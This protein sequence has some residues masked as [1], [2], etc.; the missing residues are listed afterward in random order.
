V[1][2]GD[3]VL[4]HAQYLGVVVL[5]RPA[6]RHQVVWRSGPSSSD[7]VGSDR[8]SHPG[9]ADED[10]SVDFTGR[11]L[12]SGEDRYGRIGDLGLGQVDDGLDP[13]IVVKESA[14]LVFEDLTVSRG[15]DR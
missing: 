5:E 3:A 2:G 6:H 1:W 11:D 13:V 12:L 9:A 4:A 14:D 15:A 8:G 10:G 7:L